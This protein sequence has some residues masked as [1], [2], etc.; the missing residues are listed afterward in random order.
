MIKKKICY[1]GIDLGASHLKFGIVDNKFKAI[2]KGSVPLGK[3][4]TKK[5]IVELL[6]NSIKLLLAFARE[7]NIKV[8]S[9][10]IGVPGIVDFDKGKIK[11]APPNLPEASGLNLKQLLRRKFKY[12]IFIDNDANLMALAESRIGAAKGYKNALCLTIGTGIGGGIILDDKLFRSSNFAGAEF[13]HM[14]ICY[15]GMKCNCKSS[16]CLEMYASATAM[17]KR[18]K[19]LLHQGRKSTIPKLTSG[20]LNQITIEVIFQAEKMGDKLA[21]EVISDTAE[22]LGIGITSA[23]NLLNPQIVVIG[24]GVAQVGKKFMRLIEKETKKR[25]FPAITEDLKIVQAKLGNDAGF[26]GAAI[27]AAEES[28]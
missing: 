6:Q 2:F 9:I 14:I 20:K 21:Q 23:I 13:G 28:A 25:G 10:G 18:T 17:I 15:H 1:I 26:I 22:F 4:K 11:G 16:G 8:K 7:K 24:G 3:K 5:S 27:L 19:T 12:P